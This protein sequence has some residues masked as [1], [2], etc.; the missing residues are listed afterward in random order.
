MAARKR[1][2]D[3]K[4]AG[5]DALGGQA[6]VPEEPMWD[7]AEQTAWQL[8]EEI[9][10]SEWAE[11]WRRLRRGSR[12]GPWRNDNAPYLRGI[13]DILVRPGIVQGN[14][15]KAGQIGGSEAMRTL[16]AYW[17]HCEP[18][19]MGLTLP[20]RGK[21]R[22]IVKSDVLPLFRRTPVLRELI[23]RE[24]RDTLIES[25]DLLNGFHLGLMWSGSATSMASNPYRRVINDEVD[26]FEPWTG[27]EPDAIAAT[28]VRLTSYGDQRL[29]VNVSTPTT[30][31]GKISQLFEASSVK[32]YFHAPCPHCG[33]YQVLRWQRVRWLDAELTEEAIA[34]AEGAAGRGWAHYT[35]GESEIR[36]ANRDGLAEEIRW[37][38]AW[39]QRLGKAEGRR[40]LA[41]LLAGERERAVWYQCQHCQGRIYH[42]AKT[43]MIRRG[44]WTTA[45]GFVVDFWGRRHEDAE[46]VERWP[47]ETRVG[48]HVSGLNCMWLHWGSLA[49]EWLRGQGDPA[50]LFFFVTNRL[51]EPFE[52][53]AKRV[54]ESVFAAK[55]TAERGALPAGTAPRWTWIISATIDTQP[56]SFYV[57]I[58]AWGGGMRSAR[59]WHGKVLT[60][61]ELDRLIFATKWTVDGGEFPPL[62]VA[63]ALIDS[64]GTA[65]R[66]ME[67]SRTQQV[68]QY[69]IPR[70]PIVTAIKGANRSGVGLY[71]PMKNPMSEGGKADYG[72]LRALM[73]DT[74]RANDLLSELI[75][76]G[77]KKSDG[78]GDMTAKAAEAWMLN[79]PN[80][81]EY[82]AQM[83]AVQKTV[84]PRTKAEVWTAK[85]AGV[86]HDYRDCEAY[87]I[88]G[89]YLLNVH[90]L[91]AED[92]EVMAWKR[93]ELTRASGPQKPPAE[94]GADAWTPRPL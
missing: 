21:G 29:Q 61:D 39:R 40:E 88:V 24:G 37:L 36:M 5:P 58:R 62:M 74:H 91:P 7:A 63:R 45:E 15:R 10:P 76:A 35:A 69:A 56:D 38:K 9:R 81:D 82:N 20:S 31:A 54:A 8:P 60:F 28:E 11:R 52:F 46:D 13:M 33:V 43:A 14:I 22:Q 4:P 65:D 89:A 26:K 83:A 50:A 49:A 93:Q 71:W 6:A 41:G 57:V 90:L 87:Q 32:L 34:A 3:R 19:P 92:E 27:E 86:R 85:A 23:G 79:I 12:K 73:V 48:F 30:T 94:G 70:Q 2:T 51:A 1:K 80:D 59:V 47:H 17:A 42:H 64:G 78:Q 16:M 44:M 66:L 53:R 84:D 25:I 67:A 77:V 72:H 75:V 55:C 18:D 68:Y